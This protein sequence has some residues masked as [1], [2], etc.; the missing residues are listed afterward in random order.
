MTDANTARYDP[1][2]RRYEERLAAVCGALSEIRIRLHAAGRR[3][4]EC[5]E[6]SLIDE[7]LRYVREAT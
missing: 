6:M 1:L 3:P 7:V 5:Y 4:E 2:I